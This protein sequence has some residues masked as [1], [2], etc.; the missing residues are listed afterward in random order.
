MSHTPGPWKFHGDDLQIESGTRNVCKIN[1]YI[2]EC[3]ANA[4][5]IAAAPE[6]L[7]ILKRIVSDNDGPGEFG[8][9]LDMARTVIAK[10]EGKS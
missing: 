5:L 10:A 2:P 7:D 1:E 6:M 9:A 8:W 4:R 3:G